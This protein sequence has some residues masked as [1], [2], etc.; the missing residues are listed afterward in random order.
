MLNRLIAYLRGIL[1]LRVEFA[2]LAS[3]IKSFKTEKFSA[4]FLLI[5]NHVYS[6]CM[7][8]YQLHLYTSGSCSDIYIRI[9]IGF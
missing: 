1:S 2:T 6:K 8:S 7:H 3:I 4:G 9:V 5:I